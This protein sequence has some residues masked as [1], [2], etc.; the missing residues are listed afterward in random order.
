MSDKF[1]RHMSTRWAKASVPTYGDEWDDGFGSGSDSDDAV[2]QKEIVPERFELPPDQNDDKSDLENLV[3]FE[4]P[5]EYDVDDLHETYQAPHSVADSK[6]SLVLSIDRMSNRFDDSSD[7]DQPQE[8][9]DDN[10]KAKFKHS[11]T[12]NEAVDDVPVHTP[13]TDKFKEAE[14][15]TPQSDKSYISDADSIQQEPE[16][17]V[18]KDKSTLHDISENSQGAEFTREGTLRDFHRSNEQVG[19]E[20]EHEENLHQ[21]SHSPLSH[22]DVESEHGSTTQGN[23]N[24]HGAIPLP[25]DEPTE[26]LHVP[27]SPVVSSSAPAPLVLSIDNKNF[28]DD[29][30]DDDTDNVDEDNYGHSKDDSD[31]NWGYNG[32]DTDEDDAPSFEKSKE[33]LHTTDVRT[34]RVKTDALDLLINDLQDAS[35]GTDDEKGSERFILP[36]LSHDV[37]MPDFSAYTEDEDGGETTP[38]APL[39]IPEAEAH[40]S[41]LINGHKPS[42]RK[43]PPQRNN[44]V[45]VDYSSIADAVS[46]YMD[47]H[48]TEKSPVRNSHVEQRDVHEYDDTDTEESH[49]GKP[50][51]DLELNPVLSLGSISTGKASLGS[52]SAKS[53]QNE[54]E[55]QV[56]AKDTAPD[57]NERF[58]RPLFAESR[59]ASAMSTNTF[60]M[61]SWKPN[62]NNF[63]DQFINGNDNVSVFNVNLLNN[64]DYERFTGAQSGL[65]ISHDAASRTSSISVPETIDASLPRISE[66]MDFDDDSGDA[67]DDAVSKV[68][69]TSDSVLKEKPYLN[70]L[71]KE[72]KLTPAPSSDDLPKKTATQRYS[73]LLAPADEDDKERPRSNSQ[74]L[75]GSQSTIKNTAL[76]VVAPKKFK[77]QTYVPTNWKQIMQTSQPIDRIRMLKEALVKEREFDTGLQNWLH[78]TLTL[79]ENGSNMHIG[80]IASA[81][82]QN[83]THNDIRRQNSFRSKVSIVKDKVEGTGLH[84]SSFGKRFL[85]KG[86]KLM[87][88]T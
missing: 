66:D 62:T 76:S 69:S 2:P 19:D 67:H 88:S 42:I 79:S 51:N 44:L 56:P 11:V 84:A 61:G 35:F 15:E 72:E 12:L 22:Q 18:I 53:V 86:R 16:D 20:A 73:S 31:D 30:D 32:E 71:F 58:T 54:K 74:S 77:Q 33:D 36:P 10:E 27:D 38:I 34:H 5:K 6:P 25:D 55:P 49:L 68:P 45:S 57:V 63:R 3:E 60:N 9:D 13:Q 80:R 46:G 52:M 24:L 78:E 14:P 4:A 50:D 40:K 1:G 23:S 65:G 59:R 87:K 41:F 85:K 26:P 28:D 39:S 7:E 8:K 37:S 64:D 82:Y 21:S 75:V 29:N 83:A 17:L 48:T 70:A 43:P 47:E 81:A